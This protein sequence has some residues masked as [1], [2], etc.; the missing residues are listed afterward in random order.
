MSLDITKLKGKIPES[1]YNE[2]PNVIS[3]FSINTINRM[4]H[5]LGQCSHESG[6]FKTTKENLNYSAQG[7]A[8]TFPS[9][10]AVDPKAK[11]KVPN[12]LAKSIERKPQ[13]I[14]NNAYCDRMSNGNTA[15][16]D[17]FKYSGKGYI[18]LT[19][20]DNYTL[21]DKFVDEDI[22]KNPDLVATK[23]PLTSA[24]FFWNTN[25]INVLAD[26]GIGDDIITKVTK[27]INGGTLGIDS[28]IE[29]TK[30]FYNLLK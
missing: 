14:A 24:G 5:F 11:I 17:G 21:F 23:Y 18:Q 8:N 20:K 12:A 30:G 16:N 3:K 9:R 27:K 26:V 4:A 2:L 1:V 13:E 28:R 29:L 25:K 19:G 10:F 7:L 15:S 22:V 6:N